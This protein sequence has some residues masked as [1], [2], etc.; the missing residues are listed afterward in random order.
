MRARV[1][2]PP[3]GVNAI[4]AWHRDAAWM[5]GASSRPYGLRMAGRGLLSA[6]RPRGLLG[7]PPCSLQDARA[8][9]TVEAPRYAPCAFPAEGVEGD[10]GRSMPS[11]GHTPLRKQGAY[12]LLRSSKDAI[13]CQRR[14]GGTGGRSRFLLAR[15]DTAVLA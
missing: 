14:W 7:T 6:A 11:S 1:R 4:F 10:A 15:S 8:S 9:P 12:L 5:P 2:G 13:F 3:A